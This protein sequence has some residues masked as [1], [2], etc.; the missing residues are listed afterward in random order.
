LFGPLRLDEAEQV[1]LRRTQ[2]WLL[3][4]ARSGLVA[5]D[6]AATVGALEAE[7]S[8]WNGCAIAVGRV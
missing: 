3:A 6:G 5:A 1:D 8:R 2:P 7:K 4:H